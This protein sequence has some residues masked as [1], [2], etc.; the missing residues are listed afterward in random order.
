MLRFI[1]SLR[2][3]PGQLRQMGNRKLSDTLG[4]RTGLLPNY[5]SLL[6]VCKEI[7]V[8]TLGDIKALECSIIDILRTL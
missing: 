1:S 8:P 4:C 7:F 3:S 5:N 2:S 6:V